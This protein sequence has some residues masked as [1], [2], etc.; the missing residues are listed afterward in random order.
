MNQRFGRMPAIL[1]IGVFALAG[2]AMLDGGTGAGPIARTQLQPT[3]GNTAS[4]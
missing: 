4:G 2:C 3:A 1:A